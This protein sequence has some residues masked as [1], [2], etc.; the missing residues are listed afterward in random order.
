MA[1]CCDLMTNIWIQ[2]LAS[3]KVLSV[4]C[5]WVL[6][7]FDFKGWYQLLGLKKYSL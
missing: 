5:C 1:S 2:P 3:M 4:F 7:V 6:S